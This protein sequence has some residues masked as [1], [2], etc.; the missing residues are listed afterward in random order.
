MSVNDR[1]QARSAPLKAAQ[2][3]AAEHGALPCGLPLSGAVCLQLGWLGTF[4]VSCDDRLAK[5]GLPAAAGTAAASR[6]AAAR[7]RHSAPS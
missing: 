2:G 7:T 4:S 3:R 1:L 6:C 5:G